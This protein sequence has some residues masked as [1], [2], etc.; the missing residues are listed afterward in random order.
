MGR[1]ARCP[2][3]ARPPGARSRL[4]GA[5]L[6]RLPEFD[7]FWEK[8]VEHDLFVAMHGSDSGY[9]RFYGEWEGSDSEFLP[10]K[11]RAFAE[12]WQWRPA[13]DAVGAAICHG[14]L[15][16]F[17]QL[18]MAIVELGSSW[19]EPLV[20]ELEY[21]YKKMPH[22]FAEH[23]IEVLRRNVYICPFWEEDYTYLAGLIGEE[24]LL[25]GS[26]WPH[27]EGLAVPRSYIDDL[28]AA[29]VG[30]ESIR[31]FMGE[32]SPRSCAS[33]PRSE[34]GTVQPSPRSPTRLVSGTTT[35]SVRKTS[36]NSACPVICR[37]GRTSGTRPPAWTRWRGL[38][39]RAQGDPR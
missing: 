20:K 8:V 27:P 5:A 12:L 10:F 28:A 25:F 15:S 13:S 23:P 37:S 26:D 24:H 21:L 7:P 3:R 30:E 19:L 2:R 6:V 32:T 22:E 31:R 17:P 38:L 34:G 35:T 36:L 11:P 39:R 33:Q 14:L 16:R 18:R 1:G 9:S 29:G 4:P